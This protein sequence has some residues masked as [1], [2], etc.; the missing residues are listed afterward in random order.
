MPVTYG[1]LVIGSL[2]MAGLL[3]A[4]MKGDLLSIILKVFATIWFLI[5]MWK[6]W[7]WLRF[8]FFASYTVDVVSSFCVDL[9]I[10]WTEVNQGVLA[11][12]LC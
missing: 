2:N 10:W 5:L 1:V 12:D 11:H 4:T 6:D 3:V 8:A 9:Y 7:R